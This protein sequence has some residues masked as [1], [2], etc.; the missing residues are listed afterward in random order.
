MLGVASNRPFW[1]VESV[2]RNQSTTAVA[3]SEN[4]L[5][6][7]EVIVADAPDTL[8]VTVSVGDLVQA[9]EAADLPVV[10]SSSAGDYLCNH[11][12]YWTLHHLQAQNHPARAGFLHIP[13]DPTTFATEAAPRATFTFQQHCAAVRAVLETL[14]APV[15]DNV[16]F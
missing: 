1:S 10:A 2:G 11:L 4:R 14:T 15:G 8:P 16:D 5:W 12:L 7:T 13:A 6:T 9:L 3:D